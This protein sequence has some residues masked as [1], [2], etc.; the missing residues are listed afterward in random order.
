MT[1]VSD[2]VRR[3]LVKSR[4]T[5]YVLAKRSGVSAGQLSRFASGK[6]DLYLPALAALAA[7]LGYEIVLRPKGSKRR[8]KR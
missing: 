7:A 1:T 2:R 6:R 8:T 4:A 5:H 3:L